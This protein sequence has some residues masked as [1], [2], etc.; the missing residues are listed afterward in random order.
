MGNPVLHR[1]VD[2]QQLRLNNFLGGHYEEYNL[3]SALYTKR[4]DA[5]P[6]VE[7]V[8]WPAPGRSKPTF[9]EAKEKLDAGE[10][11]AIQKGYKFGP[12]C[13]FTCRSW[14]RMRDESLGQNHLE[15]PENLVERS[16]ST[17]YVQS[18][19]TADP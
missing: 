7:M 17:T 12:G 5:Q 16:G 1:Q 3:S 19:S 2:V 9:E 18:L 8:C 13:K 6:F 14:L 4:E 11:K 10:G 15:Y